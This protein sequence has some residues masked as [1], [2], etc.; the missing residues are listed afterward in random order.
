MFNEDVDYEI[1]TIFMNFIFMLLLLYASI[2]YVQFKYLNL[3]E[4]Q[5]EGKVRFIFTLNCFF[6]ITCTTIIHNKLDF[7]DAL[8]I[9]FKYIFQSLIFTPIY[10]QLLKENTPYKQYQ[11]ERI[12]LEKQHEEKIQKTIQV[13]E[14]PHLDV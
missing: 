3:S 6:M 13:L 14:N 11:V 12:K 5:Y 8:F 1:I 10:L 2:V 4:L 9:F 7:S